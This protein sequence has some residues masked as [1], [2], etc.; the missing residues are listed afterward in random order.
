[1]AELVVSQWIS[2]LGKIFERLF[3]KELST[4]FEAILIHIIFAQLQIEVCL[5][6]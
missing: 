5:G 6:F 1:M 4:D 3:G 2:L